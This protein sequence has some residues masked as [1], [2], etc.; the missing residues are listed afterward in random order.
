MLQNHMVHDLKTKLLDHLER[1]HVLAFYVNKLFITG[2]GGMA[3]TSDAKI[4]KK[5]KDLRNL[6][7]NKVRVFSQPNRL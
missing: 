2:E 6:A 7:F 5:M 4:F 3:L 1:S